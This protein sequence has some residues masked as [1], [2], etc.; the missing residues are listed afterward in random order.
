MTTEG[1]YILSSNSP[2]DNNRFFST[3]DENDFSAKGEV[4][5]TVNPEA[6]NPIKVNVGVNYRQTDRTFNF[7]EI[8]YVTGG[9]LAADPN[10]PDAVL[11]SQN[12]SAGAFSLITIWNNS[13]LNPMY[14]IGHR[15]IEQAMHNWF[16]P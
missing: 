16:T 2:G 9:G 13:N 8:D 11:N 7:T 6:N 12:L 3:L 4:T 1:S 10:N 5:Y 15:K 14:Y